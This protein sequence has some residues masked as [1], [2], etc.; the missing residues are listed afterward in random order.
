MSDLTRRVAS[1]LRGFFRPKASRGG[2]LAFLAF[3]FVLTVQMN[4]ISLILLVVRE[5]T[6]AT[7]TERKI[8][9]TKHGKPPRIG[10]LTLAW[11]DRDGR[12]HES[13]L[14]SP[15]FLWAKGEGSPAG[16]VRRFRE[17]DQVEIMYDPEKPGRVQ[18]QRSS[19][20]WIEQG[21]YLAIGSVGA[22]YWLWRGGK[23]VWRWRVESV[24]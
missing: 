24:G 7:V 22:G 21:I 15:G 12:R 20:D 1:A 9:E 5:T 4:Y 19:G 18:V 8:V 17:G 11:I 2:F 23:W 16:I 10:Y 3:I 6:T 14:G 13:V